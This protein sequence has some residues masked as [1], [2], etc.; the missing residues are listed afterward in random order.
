MMLLRTLLAGIAQASKP[1]FVCYILVKI[2]SLAESAL[3]QTH[4]LLCSSSSQ[5]LL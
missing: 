4:P 3:N 1:Q 5:C 2:H